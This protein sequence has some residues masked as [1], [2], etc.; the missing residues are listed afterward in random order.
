MAAGMAIIT[1]TAGGCPEVIADAGLK[2]PPR[3]TEQI[4]V[5]LKKLMTSDELRKELSQKALARVQ[6]FTWDSI[7]EKYVNS[8]Q[9][10][11]ES[12]SRSK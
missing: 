4:K 11:I 6:L 9:Q 1:S 12:A 8:Y 3:N 5:S 7:T 10:I 2:V